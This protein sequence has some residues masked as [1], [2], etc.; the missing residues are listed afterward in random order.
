MEPVGD[1]SINVRRALSRSLVTRGERMKARRALLKWAASSGAL[2]NLPLDALKLY[3][4]LLVRA[5]AIGSENRMCLQTIQRILGQSF[6]WADCQQALAVL[7]AHDLLTWT[8]VLSRPSLRQ[9]AQRGRE[10]L[11]IVFQLNLPCE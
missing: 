4:L 6:S 8:P 1:G 7:A 5:E 10:S 2:D 3:L 11:E 9:R